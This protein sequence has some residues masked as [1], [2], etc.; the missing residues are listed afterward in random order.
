MPGAGRDV[1]GK[2]LPEV[3]VRMDRMQRAFRLLTRFI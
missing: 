2:R 3:W 1:G